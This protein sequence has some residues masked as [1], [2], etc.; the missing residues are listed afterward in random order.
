MVTKASN[1]INKDKNTENVEESDEEEVLV[2]DAD[3]ETES[4]D[5]VIDTDLT[6]ETEEVTEQ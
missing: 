6:N 1:S 2:E 5:L 4:T 3:N